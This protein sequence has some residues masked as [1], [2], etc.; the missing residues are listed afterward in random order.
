MTPIDRY[1]ALDAFLRVQSAVVAE[2]TLAM[3]LTRALYQIDSTGA[4]EGTPPGELQLLEA[5]EDEMYG[6]TSGGGGLIAELYA[7]GQ[8]ISLYG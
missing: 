8:A 3:T 6:T 4:P 1:V 7:Q 5:F 2:E